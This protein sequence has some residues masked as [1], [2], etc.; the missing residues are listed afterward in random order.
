MSGA[1]TARASA[2]K[3]LYVFPEPLPLDR[4]RGIQ[5]VFTVRSLAEQNIDVVLAHVPGNGDPFAACAIDRPERAEL[6]PLSYRLPWPLDRVHSNRVFYARLARRVNWRDIGAVMARH[7]KIARALLER[8]SRVPLAYEAHE[9]FAD[10]AAEDR[11][12]RVQKLERFVIERAEVLIANSQATARRLR[13]RYGARGVEV[14]PNG[15]DVAERIS[16]KDWAH[17]GEHV[18]YAGSFFAWKGVDDLVAAARDLAG[19]R[20]TLMGGDHA[21]IE[22]LRARASPAGAKLDFTGRVPHPRVQAA[23]AGACIAVLPN[24]A[25]PDSEFT[26]PI[27]LFEYMAAGCALVASDLPPVREILAQDEALWV[28]PGDAAALAHAIRTLAADPARA[29]AM[30]ERLRERAQR[31]SWAARGERLA[32]LLRPLLADSG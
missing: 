16:H 4:A 14:I 10:T 28:K 7:L 20:I 5:T 21:A 15:V 8:D 3:L 19:T 22:R 29:R 18:V 9:V 30:G 12:L 6:L 17:A 32:A 25:D 13:E 26:S 2:M 23:L 31:F 1:A 24:R 11:K 27:K